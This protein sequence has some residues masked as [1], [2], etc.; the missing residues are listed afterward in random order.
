MPDIHPCV[1]ESLI[2]P[3]KYPNAFRMAPSN[4]QWDDAVRNYCLNVLKV[5]K[6]AVIGDTTGYG[7]TAVGASVAAF[8]KDGADV[9][10][11]ANIDATQPDLTPDMLRAKNAGAEAIVVWSVTTGMEARMFNTRAT[12]NWDVPFV[13]HPS[14]SSGEIAGLVE[15]P[16]NWKKVY[17]IGYKS[18][19]YD[20]SGKLPPKSQELVERLTKAGV[21]L[22]DTLLWWV[23]GGID[24]IELFAKAV[25]TSGSTDGP[26]IIAYLNSLNKYP[27][28][29]GNYTFTPTQ[30]NGY[31]TEEIVM[32]EAS[33]AKNGTF[34]LAPGY[35]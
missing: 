14:L 26:S 1:V 18:C 29:F 21:A 22:N 28:Y 35:S 32:S 27:G 11:Q 5:K 4:S 8:K 31:A 17:A 19:S 20:A 15:K 6:I 23:A 3:A 24:A 13:G 30:H 10:Y 25:E 33:T 2:D 16:E 34:A 9:V 7:V 12:M